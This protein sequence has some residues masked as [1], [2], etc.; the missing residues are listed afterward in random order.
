MK[1]ID[2]L[3]KI[4][5][6]KSY[7]GEEDNLK[8]YIASWLKERKIKVI[9]QDQNLVFCIKGQD[10]SKAFIFNSHLDTVSSGSK[11]AWKTNPFKPLVK[12]GKIIGLGA[13]DMKAGL[14]ASLLLAEKLAAFGKPPVD[15][16]F[17]Y[18]IR[19]EE[20]G[21]GTK[22]FS[23]WFGRKGYLKK[24]KDL[25]GI[26]TEPTSLK[27]IEY[28]HRGN[29][30]FKAVVKGDSGHSSRPQFIKKHA[31]REMVKFADLLQENIKIW[32]KEFAD[33]EFESP[34]IGEFTS[35]QAGLK[36]NIATNEITEESVNKFPSSCIATF[37][38][39]TTPAFHKVAFKKI[40]ALAKK[41]GV[42]VSY[43]FSPSPAGYT[44]LDEKIIKS[45]QKVLGKVKLSV[46]QGSADL[47]FLTMN[48]I[49]AIILGP[50][51]KDQAHKVNEY[52]Y[53]DQIPQAVDIYEKIINTWAKQMEL[54]FV[55]K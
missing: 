1:H 36:I 19:E 24:Y 43:A 40:Q 45:A 48:N 13:S 39:R 10:Q 55:D 16:W 3:E 31:I 6:I 32:R 4:I 38:L 8:D 37:D 15:V 20:D 41:A 51:E 7:S 23:E 5:S 50:G 26:F 54:E 46:S 18:V 29:I 52:C 2:L 44:S 14:A 28:G 30:F 33:K 21:A 49:K 27:E 34:T 42:Q 25:T 22:S 11:S 35:I 12:N 17:T 53:P 47:G 9:K